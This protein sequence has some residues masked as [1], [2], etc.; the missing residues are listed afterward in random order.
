[1]TRLVFGFV[2]VLLAAQGGF[3][4]TISM[5]DYLTDVKG[6]HPFF[7]KE[8]IQA[9]IEEKQRDR[10]LGMED[11]VANSSAFLAYQ[12][13]VSAGPF[14]PEQ[15]YAGGI[16]A[17]AGRTFWKTGGRFSVSWV[18]NVTDQKLPD[19]VIP[20]LGGDIVVPIGPTEFFENRIYATYSHPLL[21]N[22]GGILDRLQY[23]LSDFN[24]HFSE[25]QSLEN[26]EQFLLDVGLRFLEWVVIAEELRIGRERLRFA[27]KQLE[28]V[29]RKREAYLVDEV[30]VLRAK[31]ALQVAKQ[32]VVRSESRFAARR[33]E[34]AVIAQSDEL[35]SLTPDFDIYKLEALPTIEEAV[36]NIE[37]E[38]IVAALDLRLQQLAYQKKG[39]EET[40]KPQLFLNLSGGLQQGDSDF[41]DALSLDKPDV[42]VSLD[43]RYPLGNRTAQ[44]DVSKI[45]LEVRQLEKEI[46][47]VVLALEAEIRKILIE[48][49]ELVNIMELNRTQIETAREKTREEQSRYNQGR[50]E[51]TFVIQSRDDESSAQLVY[52]LNAATYQQLVLTY[53]ALTDELLPQ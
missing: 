14:V 31:D 32:N 25:V 41:F 5:D 8:Q 13:P 3:A 48:V 53:R 46:E 42:A 10:F 12:K 2:I 20:S 35:Y 1:M 4:Q 18:T 22:R 49:D 36:E 34:L 47:S 19:I 30:D 44:N 15:V 17:G 50:G 29:S 39:F 6:R 28:T 45:D 16:E 43:F 52:A 27:E 26:Q 7:T 21:Q 9:E 40:T 24:V 33:A 11:W 38:R 23:E 37:H 51:L